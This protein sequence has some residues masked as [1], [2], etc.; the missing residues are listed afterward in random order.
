MRNLIYAFVII[1]VTAWS[2]G[3]IGYG[4]GGMMHILLVIAFI[5]VVLRFFMD[6]RAIN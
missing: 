6:K 1:L 2:I 5:G 3:F 4:I